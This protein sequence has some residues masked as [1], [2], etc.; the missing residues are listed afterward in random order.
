MPTANRKKRALKR[1]AKASGQQQLTFSPKTS[2]SNDST[3]PLETVQSS[4]E[5]Q[6][7]HVASADPSLTV[8]EIT[9]QADVAASGIRRLTTAYRSTMT[10]TREGNLNLI[11]TQ[12]LTEIDIDRV[13]AL[14]KAK[15]PR[16]LFKQISILYE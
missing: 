14:F 2:R 11:H 15:N 9:H 12:R 6:Q 16:R 8:P 4:V 5:S 7:A 13:I 3:A 1:S 10:D